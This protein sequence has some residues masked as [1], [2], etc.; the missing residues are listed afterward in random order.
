[1]KVKISQDVRGF[2]R[3]LAPEPRRQILCDLDLIESG[4]KQPEPLDEPLENFY[5][6]R[7]GRYRILCAIQSNTILALFAD[8]R[9]TVYEVA[10]AA[11]LEKILHQ[12]R[13]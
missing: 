5:K 13:E 2:L 7:S 10:S 1:M 4:K 8:R 9:S 3:S 6:V 12:M 11:F